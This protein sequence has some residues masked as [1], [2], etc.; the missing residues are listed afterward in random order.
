MPCKDLQKYD[1]YLATKGAQIPDELLNLTEGVS[2]DYQ[3][4]AA[5]SRQLLNDLPTKRTFSLPADMTPINDD[6]AAMSDACTQLGLL[7]P[8]E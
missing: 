2:A 5:A 7:K 8:P 6:L 4:L 3:P 1:N